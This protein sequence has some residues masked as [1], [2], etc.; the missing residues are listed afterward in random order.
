M[1]AVLG[2]DIIQKDSVLFG[3]IGDGIMSDTMFLFC[4]LAFII[5]ICI[6]AV[7]VAVASVTSATA[8]IVD[9]EDGAEEE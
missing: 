6:I 1:H 2:Y 7:I 9:D 3:T 5:F 8:G 4:F